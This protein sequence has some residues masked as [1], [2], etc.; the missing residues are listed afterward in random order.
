[1]KWLFALLR[2]L[3]KYYPFVTFPVINDDWAGK[4]VVIPPS[5]TILPFSNITKITGPTQSQ[6]VTLWKSKKY[7]MLGVKSGPPP[8]KQTALEYKK[9]KDA[10]STE[11]PSSIE[12]WG[13]DLETCK[14]LISPSF[15]EINTVNNSHE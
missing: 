7:R 5:G 2:D 4:P 10:S 9:A 1:M 13:T 12:K 15:L 8:W 14:V 6:L 3:T 11:M